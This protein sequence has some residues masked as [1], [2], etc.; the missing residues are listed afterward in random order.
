MKNYLKRRTENYETRSEENKRDYEACLKNAMNF[1]V[2][3]IH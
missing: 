1:F 2:A 3:K